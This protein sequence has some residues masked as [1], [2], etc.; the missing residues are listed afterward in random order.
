MQTVILRKE[1]DKKEET[2]A[3]VAHGLSGT[4]FFPRKEV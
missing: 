2:I 1:K 4:N 3:I